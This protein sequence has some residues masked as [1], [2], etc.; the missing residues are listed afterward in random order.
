[1]RTGPESDMAE[2]RQQCRDEQAE[3]WG[4]TWTAY[5][6]KLKE[7]KAIFVCK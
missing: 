2:L 7:N 5:E 3:A 6:H 1:M 4:L